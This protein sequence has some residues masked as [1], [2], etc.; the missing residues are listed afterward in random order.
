MFELVRVLREGSFNSYVESVAAMMPWMFVLD[1]VNYARWLSVH[2]RDMVQLK[3]SHPKVYEHFESGAFVVN[4]TTRVF[5]AIALNHAHE[6]KNAAAIK[7]DGGA[8]GLTESPSA[9]RRWMIG[10]PEI[11]HMVKE[12]E[13]QSI[14]E[15]KKSAKHHEQV[16]S[17][18]NA[19][20]KDVTS[21]VNSIDQLGIPF[22]EDSGDLLSMDKI[23]IYN[24]R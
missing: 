3:D 5:S 10:E 18:Q 20:F 11:A 23:D 12:F 15:K 9:L 19:F 24:A 17:T 7:G 6:Q 2:V 22:K 13:E 21:L 1:H 14:P 8:V 4:K 16:L